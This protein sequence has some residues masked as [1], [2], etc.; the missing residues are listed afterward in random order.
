MC[1]KVEKKHSI[2]MRDPPI[3]GFCSQICMGRY[4]RKHE[5]GFAGLDI[6]GPVILAVIILVILMVGILGVSSLLALAPII[7][8]KEAEQ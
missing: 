2:V 4:I 1:G 6:A 8:N 3:P 7:R 5:K